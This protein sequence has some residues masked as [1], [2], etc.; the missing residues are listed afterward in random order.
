MAVIYTINFSEFLLEN[1]FMEYPKIFILFRS[2]PP[3]IGFIGYAFFAQSFL[4]T[5]SWIPRWHKAFNIFK[6]WMI[7]SIVVIVCTLPFTENEFFSRQIPALGHLSAQIF[8]LSFIV[9]LFIT[10]NKLAHYF[11]IG[12]MSFALTSIFLG[13]VVVSGAIPII[14]GLGICFLGLAGELITFSLGLGYRIKLAEV[15]KI[16]AQ[17]ETAE[18]LTNQNLTLEKRVTERTYE[19]EKQNEEILTQ[20]EELHQQQEE[21][22][23]QRDYIEEK[24][25][26]LSY[27]N[28]QVTDSIRYAKTIQ[29]AILPF[30]ERISA[31]FESHFIFYKPKDIVSGDFYWQETIGNTQFI[32]VLDCTGHGVPGGFM[33]M[34]GFSILND[35]A[36][37]NKAQKPAEML[38]KLNQ[39]LVRALQQKD[40]HALNRDGMDVALCAI[41]PIEDNQM[42]VTFSGAKRPLYYI[43]PSGKELLEIKGDRKSIGG[44]Q[45][46]DKP[47]TNTEIIVEKDTI[48]YLTTDG[49]ADQNNDKG[50]KFGSPALRQLLGEM[51]QQPLNQQ[52]KTIDSIFKMHCGSKPQRDDV[53]IIGVKL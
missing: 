23:S 35:I 30:H 14:I 7:F 13:Y 8:L 37:K 10:K 4:D 1:V 41:E 39:N 48:L 44:Y 3:C 51:W 36:M 43:T 50:K 47:F 15:E 5:K 46:K 33:S 26:D 53:A 9:K 22:V 24:N 17:K 42:K 20:N 32:A 6:Y 18:V 19:I 29:E 45:P 28:Q 38:E 49:F 27:K 52:H 2:I 34:I 31:A 21:I 25:K 16:R 40:E 12:A 11:A